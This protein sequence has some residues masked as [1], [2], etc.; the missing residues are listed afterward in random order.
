MVCSR[1]IRL[2]NDEVS[3]KKTRSTG[4]LVCMIWILS[5]INNFGPRL[6][7]YCLAATSAERGA[8]IVCGQYYIKAIW[9]GGGRKLPPSSS[10]DRRLE[11][12]QCDLE[13]SV[14]ATSYLKECCVHIQQALCEN[15]GSFI[16][17]MYYSFDK[18]EQR[19]SVG[20]FV[21]TVN[22]PGEVFTSSTCCWANVRASCV[23]LF[24]RLGR[25]TEGEGWSTKSTRGDLL[26]DGNGYL[27]VPWTVGHK[28][29]ASKYNYVH[30]CKSIK[31]R[32]ESV[33]A[34][35]ELRLR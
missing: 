35:F 10:A 30:C 23:I 21:L 6:V 20:F 29:T 26:S 17:T 19:S 11:K 5:N 28:A 22:E 15:V 14:I 18:H 3:P 24:I 8:Q 9:C 4:K 33:S 32:T 13:I 16:L 31:E 34:T 1:A 12:D 25:E 2:Y 27:P 7:F